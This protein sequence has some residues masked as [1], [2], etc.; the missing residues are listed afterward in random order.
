MR[1]INL[2]LK[3]F[4]SFFKP[5]EIN[6]ETGLGDKKIFLIHGA[7]GAG[8]TTL[9]DAICYAL[10]EESSGGDR[11]KDDF[12]SEFADDKQEMSVEFNFAM[13]DSTY[14]IKRIPPIKK[15]A[16]KFVELYKDN[17]LL[18]SDAAGANQY[19]K[20]LMGFDA[21]Q[22]RQVVIL[23]QGKFRE[24]LTATSQKREE[25]LSVIFNAEFYAKVEKE[26]ENKAKVAGNELKNLQ[27][28]Q[29]K[30]LQDLV[31]VGEENFDGVIKK[32]SAQVEELKIA[33]EKN[34]V[35]KDKAQE[36]LKSAENL[37]KDFAQAESIQKKLQS[38]QENLKSITE[39]IT[40]ATVEY[41]K[42][43]AEEVTRQNLANK[44][45]DLQK[46]S[47]QVEEYQKT[48]AE[49]TKA[50]ENKKLAEEN[51]SHEEIL[52]KKYESRLDNLEKEI[53]K[54]Q[55]AGQKFKDAEQNLKLSQEKNQRLQEIEL[56][57]KNLVERQKQLQNAEKNYNDTDKKVKDLRHS[58]REGRAAILAKN[59][60]DGEPCPV[61]GA[62]HHPNLA[63]SA[64][65]IPSD[66]EIE[67]FEVILKRRDIEKNS[68]VKALSA[69]DEKIKNCQANV[70]K[71]A[72]VLSLENAKKIFD[73]AKADFDQ[74]IKDRKNLQDGKE[75]TKTKR[76]DFEKL[77]KDFETL[78]KNAENLS[79]AIE[80]MQ[81]QIPQEYLLNAEKISKDLRENQ[82]LLKDLTEAWEKIDAEFN[83][84][85]QKKSA[86]DALIKNETAN[87]NELSA[88]VAGKV[89]PDIET[90]K[91]ISQTAQE[92]FE[93][94]I[95]DKAE[96]QANLKQLTDNKNKFDA[97]ENEIEVANKTFELWQHLSDVANGKL[98][99]SKISFRRSYLQSIFRDIVEESN[100]RLDRMSEGRYK[101]V[102]SE[103]RVNN[104]VKS[105]GLDIKIFDAYT[106]KARIANTLSG[107]ESFLAALS[108]ALGLAAV[109]K[110]ISGGVKLDTLFID[111]GFG[112][113]DSDALDAAVEVL[114]NLQVGGRLVGII[115]HVDELKQRLPVR[116]EVKKSQSGSS[117][118]FVKV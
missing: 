29:E 70:E 10:Y 11:K 101:F 64:I 35:A 15:G 41:E 115:S 1:P 8:K 65:S 30:Y 36:D 103:E 44:I 24:F 28:V 77:K 48:F 114:E 97:L 106:G 18:T 4:G 42:R 56:L 37:L 46:I 105:G 32:F 27:T 20:N 9:L 110:N 40:S 104:R 118:E 39:K 5:T 98:S 84:L 107:G 23:P 58:Q 96:C 73:A 21:A 85:Q 78:S 92:V 55:D 80:I 31:E 67:Q 34:K 52:L 93:K 109:V 62:I 3:A 33:A 69:V 113:L 47:V 19:I 108:L 79:G 60:S 63:K 17:S 25:L 87:F 57:K 66:E 59:L 12:R 111:E 83:K 7:T 13:N 89:K 112:S 94:S 95:S 38:A 102:M 43:K 45:S 82:N 2:K 91:K 14:K 49:L 53:E 100:A 75:K 54:L 72:D 71:L 16:K 116:L 90:L 50:N 86:Q 22:F 74:L 76:D 88:K 81:K 61:C 99:D 6:F 117:A 51:I 68:A 26:L